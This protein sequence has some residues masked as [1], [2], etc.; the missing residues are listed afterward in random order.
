MVPICRYDLDISVCVCS[1][2]LS[3]HHSPNM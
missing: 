1:S 2:G 3:I